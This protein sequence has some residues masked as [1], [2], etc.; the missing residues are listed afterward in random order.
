REAVLAA[1]E[2]RDAPRLGFLLG[3]RGL[4]TRR[5]RAITFLILSHGLGAAA[6]AWLRA[7]RA[8]REFD[9]EPADSKVYLRQMEMV[10][11]KSNIVASQLRHGFNALWEPANLPWTLLVLTCLAA[12]GFW[13]VA[14]RL[15]RR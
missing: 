1:L 9:L 6:L 5:I 15:G 4:R 14:T 2:A 11:G 13:M 7:P 10:A 8:V 3:P 12:G